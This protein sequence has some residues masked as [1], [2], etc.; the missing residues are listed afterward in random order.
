MINTVN[1]SGYVM[2]Q[3]GAIL[4]PTRTSDVPR[5]E[6]MGYS[7]VGDAVPPVPPVAAGSPAGNDDKSSSR[8][9]G[10]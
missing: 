2:M 3:N 5:W 4:H 7:V 10:R 9:G 6:K 8:R 1:N